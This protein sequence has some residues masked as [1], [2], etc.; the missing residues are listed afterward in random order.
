MSNEEIKILSLMFSDQSFIWAVSVIISI[1]LAVSIDKCVSIS[2][3]IV[4][5]SRVTRII[6]R[7]T[8]ATLSVTFV[9]Y[10]YYAYYYYAA[11]S[12]GADELKHLGLITAFFVL[13]VILINSRYKLLENDRKTERL[14]HIIETQ[15]K[16]YKSLYE[17]DEALAQYRHNEKNG[18]LALKALLDESKTDD[19]ARCVS[20]MLDLLNNSQTVNTHNPVID[21]IISSKINDGRKY[22]INHK[23]SIRISED[24]LIDA[25]DMGVML[26]NAL[27]NANEAVERL[28]VDERVVLLNMT[29]SN[30][31]I[32]IDIK[33]PVADTVD[34]RSTSK[35]NSLEHGYGIRSITA[36]A[37]KYGGIFDYDV[38][39]GMFEAVITLPNG[40]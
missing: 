15:K 21:A 1:F 19:A 39:D 9:W 29:A 18:L 37:Q 17:R 38:K 34:V 22:S 7:F 3:A 30:N 2:K 23:I 35:F 16:H 28:P 27:D 24:I 31:I 6:L 26:G 20:D 33:N 25:Y 32:T 5:C 14:I 40:G 4:K 13:I 10:I 12:F 36:T 11:S 8:I